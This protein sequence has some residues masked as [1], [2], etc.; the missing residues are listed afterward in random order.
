MHGFYDW[1]MF[2]NKPIQYHEENPVLGR[3][4]GP[5]IDVGT[6]MIAKT[7]KGN[8][9]LLHRSTY[10]RLKEEKCR[11]KYNISLR[12]VFD[13]NIEDRFEPDVSLDDFPDINL[14]DTPLYD[15][16]DDYTTDME[17]GLAGNTEDD[18]HPDM[19]I[20]LRGTNA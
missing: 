2:R 19:G 18:E 17:D 10:H 13:S 16:Y 8:V 4:L 5:S 20:G 6:E 3:Y 14:E 9:E 11:N 1:I 15:I 12:K 7:M